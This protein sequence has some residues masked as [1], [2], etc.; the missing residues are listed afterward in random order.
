[1]VA[2][3]YIEYVL[4]AL[5]YGTSLFAY[6]N[7]MTDTF[8]VG[9]WCYTLLVLTVCLFIVAIIRFCFPSSSGWG[10]QHD[11]TVVFLCCMIVFISFCQTLYGLGQ[12]L[13]CFPS[14]GRYRM[15]GSF[16]NP[17][18]FAASLVAVFPFI[19]YCRK[20]MTVFAVRCILSLVALLT[21]L[22]ILLS[23]SRSGLTAVVV[24][25]GWMLYRKSSLKSLSKRLLAILVLTIFMVGVYFLKKDSADGR[26]LIWRCSWDMIKE[27]LLTGWGWNAFRAHYMDYQAAYF[28]CHPNSVYAMLADNVQSPFNEFLSF[29]LC[30]GI[31]GVLFLSVTIFLLFRFC[32]CNRIEPIKQTAVCALLGIAVF[33]FFSYPFT[34]P[35][36]WILFAF[37]IYVL[38]KDCVSYK[39][40]RGME[41]VCFIFFA[42]CAVFLGGKVCQRIHAEYKWKKVAYVPM[43]KDLPVYADLYSILGKDP[44]FLYN[45][46]FARFRCGHLDEGLTL[47]LECRSLWADY[48]LEVLLGTIYIR[49]KEYRQAELHYI[50]ASFM[51]PCRFIPL[52]QLFCL[53]QE[54]GNESLAYDFAKRIE[55]KEVKVSSTTVKQIKYKVK[56]YMRE[57]CKQMERKNYEGT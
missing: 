51:C 44:Y 12:W 27:S 24:M 57:H 29:L 50:K 21:I 40:S 23:C 25:G 6:S 4:F 8:I 26:L 52:Y 35:S 34:Y 48:D 18:G 31:I 33:S 45:Y 54:Q 30:F 39:P 20:S 37:C 13:H 55:A 7:A 42:L 5:L 17:A 19:L 16:D 15:T 47:A 1:M 53:Y 11:K 28:E 43:E 10:K 3:K 36:V 41:R 46:A 14:N 49:K 56:L 38:I 22:A 9:K 2:L 32:Q